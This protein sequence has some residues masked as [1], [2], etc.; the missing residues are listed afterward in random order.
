M[1]YHIW[2]IAN[3]NDC[4]QVCT[5]VQD[6]NE[7]KIELRSLIREVLQEE[8]EAIK[9]AYGINNKNL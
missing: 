6:N 3:M 9:E 4:N 7:E 5:Q 2:R 8:L 1:T